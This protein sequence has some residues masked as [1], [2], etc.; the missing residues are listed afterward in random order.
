M[1]WFVVVRCCVAHCSLFLSLR[2]ALSI[3]PSTVVVVVDYD[4][5]DAKTWLSNRHTS[6]PP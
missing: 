5:D 6:N 2:P 3:T 4:D 1:W